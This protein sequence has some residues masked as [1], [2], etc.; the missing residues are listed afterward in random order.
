MSQANGRVER[1]AASP[2]GASAG[3]R[4]D[5][6]RVPDEATGKAL[7][8]ALLKRIF[9]YTWPYRGGLA[10]AVLLL[11]A[12]AAL[13]LAQ[14]YLLKT[15]IDEHITVHRLAGLDRLGVL[16]LLALLGQTAT[17]FAQTYLTQLIGQKAMNDLR[18]EV[19]GHVLALTAAFFDRT[20]LGRLM[21]RL[22]SDVEALTEMFASGLV[23]LVGDVVRLGFILVVIFRLD[24]KLALFSM[25][26]A[27]VLYAIAASFRGWVRDAFRE[28]RGK[29]ARLN[30]FLQEHLSG[31]KVVQVFAQEARVAREFDVINVEYRRANARAIFA[32]ASIYSIVEAVGSIAV[33]ALLWH[34]GRRIAGGTLTFGILVAFIEYLNKFFAPIRDLSTKYTVMQ[35]AMAAA[36]RVFGLL[37]TVEPDAPRLPSGEAPEVRANAPLIELD[38]VTFGYRVDRPV[39]SDVSLRIGA[40]ETVA[41]VGATGAGKST[42]I[43]L[44]PRLY[45]VTSG[46]IRI[47]GVDTR[48]L[49]RRALRRRLVVVSQD[50][51]MF[52][53]T[54]RDNIGLGEA[55][56]TDAQ[57]LEAA[58]RVGADRV[59]T[60]RPEG[61]DT[62][63]TERGANFSAGERQLVAFARA[64]ARDPEI[65]VL[66]EATA[67]VDPET[68]RTIE[69]GIGE[70]MRGRTSIVIAHRLSTIKR[71]SRILVVHKGR[72]EEEGTHEEL[73]ARGGHYALLYR[74]QMTGHAKPAA[75]ISAG[76]G[77]PA[78]G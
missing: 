23:S 5:P 40:G 54:L 30:A 41:F 73:L 11:P 60:A 36:E 27:P 63:V 51:F 50:V 47:D 52:A 9:S 20:P 37:D 71:A 64:L 3:G 14:P 44:L 19:H 74:L 72:V 59:I 10:I 45:D 31:I 34:G 4:G 21:T 78:A 17:G 24:W 49:D 35:Q 67:S 25:A 65:L 29:L 46:T 58:R 39:L 32:D 6:P 15:A 43:K 12:A 77:L 70:L 75:A 76:N 42:V 55:S 56:L 48:A 8:G 69:R 2:R 13:E 22:T 1:S 7:D 38:H 18:V 62:P 33:A 68:E 61:L 28:I 66:D 57:L 16:Y 53:G 26:S